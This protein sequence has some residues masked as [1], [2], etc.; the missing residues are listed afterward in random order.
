MTTISVAMATYNGARFLQEQL[1]SLSEQTL[2]PAELVVTDD[3]ST[4]ETLAVLAAFAATAP[5]AVRVETNRERLGYRANFMKAAKLC[6]GDIIAFCDQDDVWL[7]SKLEKCMELL[8]DEHMLMVYHNASVVNEYLEDMGETL[9]EARAPHRMNPSLSLGPYTF[10]QGFTEVM[11][12][13]L[14][15]FDAAW[16]NSSDLYDRKQREPHDKWF[17]Y[18]ASSLGRVGYIK[19]PLA[20][21]RRHGSATTNLNYSAGIRYKLRDLFYTKPE[22]VLALETCFGYRARVM[23]NLPYSL[24]SVHAADAISAAKKYREMEAFYR[25]RRELYI[26]RKALTRCKIIAK[27]LIS[28]C[29]RSKFRWGVGPRALLRD[30]LFGILFPVHSFSDS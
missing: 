26:T 4:D 20:L 29:Y 2:L 22:G 16:E 30:V 9:E 24:S 25:M 14:L 28:G 21:Y 1:Q 6:T 13:S 27:L 7:P 8:S 15:A 18:L 17:F 12:R 3:G 23:E 11:R 5:F 10:S 19:E